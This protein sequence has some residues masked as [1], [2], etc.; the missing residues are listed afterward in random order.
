MGAGPLIWLSL[1]QSDEGDKTL[2]VVQ[3]QLTSFTFIDRDRG[4]DVCELRFH[5]R[6]MKL[7]DEPAFRTGQKLLVTWGWPG[8]VAIPRRMIVKRPKEANLIKLL[9]ESV[10]MDKFVNDRV[11]HD[12]FDSDA[13][14]DIAADNGYTGILA[15]VT[16]TFVKRPNITQA[17]TDTRMLNVLARRNGFV[18]YIDAA[19]LHFHPRRWGV[20]PTHHFAYLNDPGRGNV[21][22][23]PSIQGRP[24][25]YAT[26]R[27]EAR[28]PITKE[29]VF[30]EVGVATD[31]ETLG[32]Y[33]NEFYSLGAEEEIGDPDNPDGARQARASRKQRVSLGYASQEEVNNEAARRYIETAQGR[34]K[35]S[36]TVRGD[37]TLGAKQLHYWR[38][39]SEAFT[40]LWYCKE[41]KTVIDGSG[42][43]V[44]NEYRKDALGKI[45]AAKVLGVGRKKNEKKP[46]PPHFNS[47]GTPKDHL[48]KHLTWGEGPD[49]Q[50]VPRWQYELAT[51]GNVGQ[52]ERVTADEWSSLPAN[53]RQD[54]LNK[55]AGGLALPGE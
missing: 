44:T 45:A 24:Q 16:Q 49:G 54:L 15:D 55:S 27:V 22:S 21:L 8:S 6:N 53:E 52:S 20:Q 4:K 1:I 38:L 51:G 19:G 17:G 11:W 42:Y 35:M 32:D 12:R 50:P 23:V 36:V 31:D 7:L 29:S 28:D 39:P 40:G 41:G 26:V 30:A 47:D 2:E 14:Y 37:P 46:E 5:D 10:L 33:L 3:E 18:W 34:Y 9:D 43:K 25:D 13:V 48:V